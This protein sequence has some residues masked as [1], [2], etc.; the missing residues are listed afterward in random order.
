MK[1]EAAYEDFRHFARRV[2]EH[3]GGGPSGRHYGHYLVLSQDDEILSLNFRI[4]QLALKH[5]IV[6]EM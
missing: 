6:L 4:M 3:K 5:G 2:K 1:L